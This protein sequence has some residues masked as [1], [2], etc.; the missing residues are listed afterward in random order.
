MYIVVLVTAKDKAEAEHI[1]QGLLEEKLI[2][3][4]NILEGVTSLFWWEGKIDRAQEVLLILKT[5]KGLFSKLKQSVKKRHS[6]DVPEIIALSI[7]EGNE[8][9]LKW[10]GASTA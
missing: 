2:A 4:A 3:C 8:D 6:Y 7:A 10:V 9:Y 1:A 5:K